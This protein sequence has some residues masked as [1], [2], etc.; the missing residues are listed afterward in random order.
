MGGLYDR[1][2][3]QRVYFSAYQKGAGEAS[4]MAEQTGPVDPA[5]PF[6]REHRLYQVDFLMRR[7][8]FKET[9]VVFDS[10]GNLSL[11]ADPKEM[12]ART[13][14]DYFP[15]GREP[16]LAPGTAARTG[17]RP[18]DCQAH[19]PVA[20]NATDTTAERHRPTWGPT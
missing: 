16:G 15:H 3:L 7:Y 9:D 6:M 4:L 12:W 19:R 1:L 5:K 11:E 17:I 2:K 10:G 14:P 18:A 20:T 13:H 8:G